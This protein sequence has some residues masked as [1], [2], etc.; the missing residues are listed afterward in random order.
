MLFS[1]GF[2]FALLVSFLKIGAGQVQLEKFLLVLN[3]PSKPQDFEPRSL[4]AE[5]K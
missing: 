4:L 5:G 3:G 2:L 1:T